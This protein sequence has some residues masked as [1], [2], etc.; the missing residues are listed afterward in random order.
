MCPGPTDAALRLQS[1]G[2][3]HVPPVPHRVSR[4]LKS[5]SVRLLHLPKWQTTA[6]FRRCFVVM[7]N[8]VSG[9]I[10]L[11]LLTVISCCFATVGMSEALGMRT[12]HR[13]GPGR[14]C[15]GSLEVCGARDEWAHRRSLTN[16]RWTGGEGRGAPSSQALMQGHLVG[17]V[18]MSLG[19]AVP[20]SKSRPL[21]LSPGLHRK[22]DLITDGS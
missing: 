5:T 11:F 15:S 1:P 20:P 4:I 2:V 9:Q 8:I 22:Q 6:L 18:P 7:I 13:G 10:S 17:Q 12:S 21:P 16:S 19:K 3:W 14:V